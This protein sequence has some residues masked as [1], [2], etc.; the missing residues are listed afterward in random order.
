MRRLLS[1]ILFAAFVATAV[2][3][4]EYSASN[5]RLAGATKDSIT[6]HNTRIISRSDTIAALRTNIE[7]FTTG[8]SLDLNM[9]KKNDANDLPVDAIDEL[10]ASMNVVTGADGHLTVS[11]AL[12]V[13]VG[14]TLK[15]NLVS[16]NDA[17]DIPV[18]AIDELTASSFVVTG[19]DGHLAVTDSIET[20]S[21]IRVSGASILKGNVALGLTTA[22]DN[23]APPS[24]T[25]RG[26]ADSD[27]SAT[28]S[29]TL[30]L[31]LAALADPASTLWN[32]A[33]TQA[34]GYQFDG[35]IWFNMD[36]PQL[37]LY[38]N[39][40]TTAQRLFRM[41]TDANKTI[42]T[43][44]ADNNAST[45]QTFMAFDH[46]N[47]AMSFG[48]TSPAA[49]TVTFGDKTHSLDI[50]ISDEKTPST[51]GDSTFSAVLGA[52]GMVTTNSNLLYN[53]KGKISMA[54]HAEYSLPAGV[55]GWGRVIIGDSQEWA[56][57]SFTSAAAVTLGHNSANVSTTADTDTKMNVSDGT[58]HVVIDNELGETLNLVIDVNYYTP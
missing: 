45:N 47:G 1:T 34:G 30:T 37:L 26:D 12:A 16:K 41:C 3:Q 8:D 50:V 57:F 51:T 39:N 6:A 21:G 15:G 36:A 9:G 23:T 48:T 53:I 33:K 4:V 52:N 14:D 42:F 58:D 38:D 24:F 55:A 7:A 49:G 40:S 32:F 28:T 54:D 18:D 11:S 10:T 27:A 17:N 19:V 13:L 56:E 46:S 44:R 5:S 22:A 35:K 25:I 2:G 29:E 31:S 20:A 43:L